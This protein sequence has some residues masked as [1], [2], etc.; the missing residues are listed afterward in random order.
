[1]VT[2]VTQGANGSVQIL[3]DG[4]LRYTPTPGFTGSDS[5]SYT[6]ADGSTQNVSINVARGDLVWTN[7][8]GDNNWS[9]P[10]NWDQGLVPTAID[11]VV[12][13]DALGAPQISGSATLLALHLSDTLTINGGTLTL[14]GASTIESTGNLILDGAT[15]DGATVLQSSGTLTLRGGTVTLTLDNTGLL[16]AEGGGVV[17]QGSADF[18]NTGTIFVPPGQSLQILAGQFINRGEVKGHGTV[19]VAASL[20]LNEG[21]VSPGSSPGILTVSGNYTQTATGVLNIELG[22]PVAGTQYDQL[23]VSGTATLAGNLNLILLN[24]FVPGPNDGIQILSAGSIVGDFA[25][26]SGLPPGV[27]F[28]LT[29][30]FGQGVTLPIPGTSILGTTPVGVVYLGVAS[31]DPSVYSGPPEQSWI[32]QALAP[33]PEDYMV[34]DLEWQDMMEDIMATI[35]GEEVLLASVGYVPEAPEAAEGMRVDGPLPDPTLEAQLR[36]AAEQFTEEQQQ[37]LEQLRAAEEVLTCP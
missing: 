3:A 22:G 25:T 30:G 17:D 13:P 37:I 28:S 12:V 4:T 36:A 18:V 14:T 19:D 33:P 1:V 7:A 16:V 23:I 35:A 2:A 11:T 31:I 9:N 34:G 20:F 24:G 5:F 8:T 32:Y 26:V 27:T 10:G 21:A 15:L 29:G 6:V